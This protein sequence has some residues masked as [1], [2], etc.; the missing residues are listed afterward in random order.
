[1]IARIF[2]AFRGAHMR[3]VNAAGWLGPLDE[4]GVIDAATASA[5]LFSLDVQ[6]V[7]DCWSEFLVWAAGA[8]GGSTRPLEE[9]RLGAPAPRPRQVFAIGLNYLDHAS[10]AAMQAPSDSM[11]VFTKFPSAITGPFA[12]VELP[13][14]SVDFE[15]ELVAV[16]GRSAYRVAAADAWEYV[17]GLTVGQDLSERELQLRPPTTQFSLGKSFPGFAP[18]GPVLVTVD[19][20]PDPD[21]L[22]FSCTLNGCPMQVSRTKLMIFPTAEIISRLSA[23]LPLYPGGVIST[24]TPSGIGRARERKVLLQLGDELVTTIDHIGAMRTPFAASPGRA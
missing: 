12:T 10:E 13:P 2:V 19:E 1:M 5:G 24:G 22:E 11:V 17:A 20:L 9:M 23:L 6:A 3:I 8:T 14:G 7:Y 21:H 15:T 16:V 4:G 18:M